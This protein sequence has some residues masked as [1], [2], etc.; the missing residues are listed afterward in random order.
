MSGIVPDNE[1]K[2]PLRKV[3]MLWITDFNPLPLLLHV[4]VHGLKG[5]LAPP[6]QA[7]LLLLPLQEVNQVM[8]HY[9]HL[10]GNCHILQTSVCVTKF[11]DSLLIGVLIILDIF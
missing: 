11:L 4:A 1:I 6:P 7:M 9:V 3:W 2:Q 8:L 10:G 5:L